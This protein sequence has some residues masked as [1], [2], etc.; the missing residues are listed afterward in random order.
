MIQDA[1]GGWSAGAAAGSCGFGSSAIGAGA[2]STEGGGEDVGGGVAGSSLALKNA[3]SSP[4]VWSGDWPLRADSDS[5]GN[6]LSGRRGRGG[7]G[8]GASWVG[9]GGGPCRRG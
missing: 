7:G 5:F 8:G 1:I 3:A 6:G 9:A 4:N 2:G